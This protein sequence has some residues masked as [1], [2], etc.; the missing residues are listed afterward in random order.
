AFG[1]KKYEVDHII[2]LTWE[3][4]DDWKIALNPDNLQLLCKSCHNKKTGEYKRG[5]GVSLW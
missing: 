5:K 4:L 1:A 3:N 2:E